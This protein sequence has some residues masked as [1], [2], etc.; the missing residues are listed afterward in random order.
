[1]GTWPEAA[2]GQ[3]LNPEAPEVEA[4]LGDGGRQRWEARDAKEAG[5]RPA[6]TLEGGV[7]LFVFCLFVC[8]WPRRLTCWILVH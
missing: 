3:S 5:E 2:S 6:G 8:L 7:F 1:M 4:F